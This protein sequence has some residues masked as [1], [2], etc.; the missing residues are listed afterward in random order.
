MIKEDFF[1]SFL[2]SVLSFIF[3]VS[4]FSPTKIQHFRKNVK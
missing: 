1:V 3:H 4:L 2:M